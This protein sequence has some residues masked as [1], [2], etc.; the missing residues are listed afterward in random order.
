MENDSEKN[1][2]MG[3][4]VIAVMVISLEKDTRGS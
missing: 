4:G 2:L 1:I 3:K